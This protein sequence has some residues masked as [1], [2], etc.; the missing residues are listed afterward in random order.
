MRS[1]DRL[2]NDAE[3]LTE[4]SMDIDINDSPAYS[5]IAISYALIAI[6][7]ELHR[8]NERADIEKDRQELEEARKDRT[9]AGLEL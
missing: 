2:I 9:K 6:A 4:K 7:Q 5:Q 1:F 3:S 8:M